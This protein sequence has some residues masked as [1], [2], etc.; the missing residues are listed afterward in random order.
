M[1]AP[2]SY[3]LMEVIA[4]A[5]ATLERLREEDGLVLE[6]EDE[7]RSALTE[8]GIGADEI[9]SR[10]GRAALDATA[11]VEMTK[12]RLDNLKARHARFERQ[13]EIIRATLLQA[14][15]AMGLKTFRDPEFNAA[16]ANG[17]PKVIV[18]YVNALPATC[19]RTKRE[20]DKTMIKYLLLQ[21]DVVPGALL[22]NAEPFITIGSK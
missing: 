15:Q 22:S 4:L 11:M 13:E 21:E 20:P 12:A 2:S 14:M 6:T 18:T 3:H 10:L 8:E 16:V 1:S 5:Q 9:L 17:K 19:V 7:L